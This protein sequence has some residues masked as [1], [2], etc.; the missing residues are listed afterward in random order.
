MIKVQGVSRLAMLTAKMATATPMAPERGM[1]P[2]AKRH[3]LL[4]HQAPQ[5]WMKRPGPRPVYRAAGCR[6]RILSEELPV[7]PEWG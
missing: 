4:W 2:L 3:R 7:D 5:G 1:P 6:S